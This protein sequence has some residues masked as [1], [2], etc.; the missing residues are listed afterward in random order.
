[1]QQ[2]VDCI[3]GNFIILAIFSEMS[4]DSRSHNQRGRK[5]TLFLVGV[6]FTKCLAIFAAYNDPVNWRIVS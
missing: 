2:S 3:M 1:M 6:F 4:W 5:M